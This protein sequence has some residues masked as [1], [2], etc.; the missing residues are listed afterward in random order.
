MLNCSWSECPSQES[1]NP[2]PTPSGSCTT[3][4]Y[5]EPQPRM[6]EGLTVRTVPGALLTK[7]CHFSAD[8]MSAHP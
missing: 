5:P 7:D 1:W 4:V 2:A 6:E 8:R 3:R